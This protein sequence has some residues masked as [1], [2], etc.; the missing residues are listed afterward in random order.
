MTRC[1]W[2]LLSAGCTLSPVVDDSI[3]ETGSTGATD[4]GADLQTE[5]TSTTVFEAPHRAE[6]VMVLD[7]RAAQDTLEWHL[8]SQWEHLFDGFDEA[9]VDWHVGVMNTDPLEGGRLVEGADQVRWITATDADHLT[10]MSDRV[11]ELYF[12]DAADHDFGLENILVWLESGNR[13]HEP[14]AETHFVVVSSRDDASDDDLA[15]LK[16]RFDAFPSDEGRIRVSAVVGDVETGC[17]SELISAN[18]GDRYTAIADHLGG[19]VRSVCMPNFR[20]TLFTAAKMVQ[21]IR[22]P[23]VLEVAAVPESVT[24]TFRQQGDEA[25]TLPTF[26]ADEWAALEDAETACPEGQCYVWTLNEG[27]MSLTVEGPAYAVGDELQVDYTR[28]L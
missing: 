10:E 2:F 16:A 27:A 12:S 20:N 23:V 6:L 21:Q 4:T 9:Q 1:W 11:E 7:N 24:V 25:M 28:A 17:S 14:S 18:S 13:G 5:F 19:M 3:G 26:S 8:N 22:F 15:T